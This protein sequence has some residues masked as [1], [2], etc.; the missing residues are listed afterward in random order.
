[1]NRAWIP[2]GALA[3]VSVAGLL[4]LGPLTDS[5]TKPVT[6]AASAPATQPIQKKSAF[7]PVSISLGAKGTTHTKAPVPASLHSRGGVADDTSNAGQV[8]LKVR[9]THSAAPTTSSGTSHTTTAPPPPPAAKPKK[10]AVKRPAIIGDV[11]ESNPDS[12]LAGGD[13]TKTSLG[14]QS[15]TPGSTPT[16]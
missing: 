1:M 12:G 16:P 8:S 14:E 9:S 13:N 7:V 15:S 4:A 2:A 3:G 5:L 11:G 10:K 6:F